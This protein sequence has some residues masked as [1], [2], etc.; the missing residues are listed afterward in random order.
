MPPDPDAAYDPAA[1]LDH[2]WRAGRTT[3]PGMLDDHAAMA[4]AALGLYEAT[5]G[6]PVPR[7]SPPLGRRPASKHFADPVGGGYFLTADDAE[8]LIVRTKTVYDN[9]TPAGKRPPPWRVRPPVPPSPRRPCGLERAEALI[10]AFAGELARNFF[11]MSTWLNHVELLHRAVQVVVVGPPDAPETRALTRA[12][13]D[14]S[15]P[16][17][18]LVRIGPGVRLPETHP[19]AGKTALDGRP[20]AYLCQCDDVP[21]PGQPT[22]ASWRRP[23]RTRR[24]GVTRSAPCR[25]PPVRDPPAFSPQQRRWSPETDPLGRSLP[26]SDV[27]AAPGRHREGDNTVLPALPLRSGPTRS[28]GIR[29]GQRHPD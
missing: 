7:S 23:L 4:G 20:T 11:P 12:A 28:D 27:R 19:A 8:T 21:A 2:A 6:G 10:Q 3:A 24:S 1:R 18:L 22:P 26:S 17:R 15:L 13:L 9:A 14:R 5:G 25:R 29:L 16:N